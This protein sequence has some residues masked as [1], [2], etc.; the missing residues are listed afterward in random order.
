MVKNKTQKYPGVYDAT[1]YPVEER[2]CTFEGKYGCKG[3][4]TYGSWK[5]IGGMNK[6]HS[7]NKVLFALLRLM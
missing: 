7:K 2:V 5:I 4:N 1:K 6:N 3:Y